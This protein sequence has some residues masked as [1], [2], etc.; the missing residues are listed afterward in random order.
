M[1]QDSTNPFP[2]KPDFDKNGGL[3]PAIIQDVSTSQVLMMGYMNEEAFQKTLEEKRVT[4]FSRSKGRLWTKGETSGHFLELEVCKIDCDKDTLL[5]KVRPLGPVCHTGQDTCFGEVNREDFLTKL[6]QLIRDYHHQPKEDSYTS[7][8]FQK[9]MAKIAQKVGEEA[10][11]VVIEA[12]KNEEDLF[13]NECADLLF[14]L[15]V[16]LEAKGSSFG[17]IVALLESRHRA[18][19]AD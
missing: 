14:H 10:V 17:E 9:G 16:L 4:F 19:Q 7:S 15:L 11:E 1:K 5:L 13:K 6:Q 2:L 12:M 3:I 18:K 8:L